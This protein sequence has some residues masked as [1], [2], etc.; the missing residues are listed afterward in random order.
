MAATREELGVPARFEEFD[1]AD[2][3]GEM[4]AQ[5]YPCAAEPDVCCLATCRRGY[6]CTRPTG[7]EGPHVAHG[8]SDEVVAWWPQTTRA[9]AVN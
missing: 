9:E 7:H 8:S 6:A 2:P 4:V 3:R 5:A 1:T